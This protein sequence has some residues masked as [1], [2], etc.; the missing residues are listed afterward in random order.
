MRFVGYKRATMR[1]CKVDWDAAIEVTEGL[2]L[3]LHPNDPD[4]LK[5]GR[6]RR[7]FRVEAATP[8]RRSRQVSVRHPRPE[9][10]THEVGALVFA[11]ADES[12]FLV[13]APEGS[14]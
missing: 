9:P 10:I 8:G 1:G 7:P 4:D 6:L 11:F 2:R 13:E 3:A 14:S 12:W 5:S